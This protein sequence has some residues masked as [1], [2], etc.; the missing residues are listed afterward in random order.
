MDEILMSTRAS[1]VKGLLDQ[2]LSELIVNSSSKKVFQLTRE[3]QQKP[4][5]HN[6]TIKRQKM[7]TV[8]NQPQGGPARPKQ[9]T[10][11]PKDLK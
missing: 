5:T 8:S 3:M 6:V 10:K 4:Q 11:P 1:R 2:R 7:K 9:H